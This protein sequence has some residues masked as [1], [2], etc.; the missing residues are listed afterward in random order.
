MADD[1]DIPLVELLDQKV[2]VFDDVNVAGR[3]ATVYVCHYYIYVYIPLN[4]SRLREESV[5]QAMSLMLSAEA[6]GNNQVQRKSCIANHIVD[7][8]ADKFFDSEILDLEAFPQFY[9]KDIR[10]GRYSDSHQEADGSTV[11]LIRDVSRGIE[12]SDVNYLHITIESIVDTK[13]DNFGGMY[14]MSLTE[15]ARCFSNKNER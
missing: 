12:D 11:T 7:T 15:S 1:L 14:S 10:A 6:L 4:G 9:P 2:Y 8:P 3:M 5:N 13:H